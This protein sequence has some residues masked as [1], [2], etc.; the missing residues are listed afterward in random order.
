MQKFIALKSGVRLIKGETYEGTI[1]DGYVVIPEVG[2]FYLDLFKPV[3]KYPYIGKFVSGKLV[4][5]LGRHQTLDA[6]VGVV[7]KLGHSTDND[8]VGMFYETWAEDAF[9]PLADNQAAEEASDILA[10]YKYLK[11][12]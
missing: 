4:L 5:F 7:L 9:E 8:S 12:N 1:V 6:A 11:G 3:K 2:T 10:M